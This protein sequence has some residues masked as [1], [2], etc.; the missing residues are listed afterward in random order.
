MIRIKKGS[1]GVTVD[2]YAVDERSGLP[3]T[4][5]AYT[6][7]AAS[8][9]RLRSARQAINTA[10]VGVTDGHTDGGFVEI[11]SANE[12]GVYRFDVPDAAIAAGADFVVIVLQADETI[13]LPLRVQLVEA[14]AGDLATQLHL[15]K[16]ALVNKREH[17]IS[18]GVDVIK[19]DDQETTLV[20]MTP[21]DG[22]EDTIIITPS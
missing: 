2:L 10:S 6:D 5:L 1:T 7:I 18:T 9:H 8:Y 12:K 20:T 22:G 19:D 14:E 16:A 3:K 11:D 21:S 15:C 17:T 13:I 4:G